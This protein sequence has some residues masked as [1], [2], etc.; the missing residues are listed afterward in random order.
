MEPIK[1]QVVL[2]HFHNKLW[3]YYLFIPKKIGDQ[4]IEEDNKRII[5]T[6]P[7]SVKIQ[8][9][10]MPKDEGYS[11]YM[12]NETQKKLGVEEGDMIEVTLEKDHSEYGLPLPESF[13]MLLDQD[14]EGRDFFKKLTMGKQRSLIYIISK[15]KSVNSQL[16]KGLAILHHL[17]E[18]KGEL[19][20]KRLNELIKEYNARKDEF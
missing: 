11:I 9:G 5:C 16:A 8:S 17:R 15:V 12:N 1:L 2:R 3:S 6:L 13:E 19:D 7:N 20:F 18:A 4:F 14:L 10:L